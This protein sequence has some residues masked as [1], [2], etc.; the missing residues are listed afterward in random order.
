MDDLAAYEHRL[1]R[2]RAGLHR[3]AQYLRRQASQAQA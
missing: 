1:R 2:A 3:R